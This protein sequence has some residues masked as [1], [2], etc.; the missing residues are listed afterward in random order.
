MFHIPFTLDDF[1]DNATVNGQ[2]VAVQHAKQIVE[3][4]KSFRRSFSTL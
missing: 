4:R 3:R 2:R 1:A